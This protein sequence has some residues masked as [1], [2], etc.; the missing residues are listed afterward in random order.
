MKYDKKGCR[1]SF[2]FPLTVP[3]PDLCA[4][5]RF[6]PLMRLIFPLPLLFT[7]QPSRW[8]HYKPGLSLPLP[9]ILRCF[10]SI[11]KQQQRHLSFYS[12]KE[13]V[14][15]WK[16]A[17][18]LWVLFR[19]LKKKQPRKMW[20]IWGQRS[21]GSHS[22]RS[23]KAPKPSSVWAATFRNKVNSRHHHLN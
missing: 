15:A 17:R 14:I 18:I 21:R 20:W 11:D 6:C 19:K 9:P 22:R 1:K 2:Y 5:M 4:R 10:S 16:R 8:V 3:F 23:R 7:I 12:F 13:K